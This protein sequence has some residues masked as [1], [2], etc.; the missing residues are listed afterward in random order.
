M[1]LLIYFKDDLRS[2]G[3]EP[4]EANIQSDTTRIPDIFAI[5]PL[6]TSELWNGVRSGISGF[7]PACRLFSNVDIQ[8]PRSK[9]MALLTPFHNSLEKYREGS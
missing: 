9:S 7:T 2:L 3:E 1:A 8:G 4:K 5:G 6:T